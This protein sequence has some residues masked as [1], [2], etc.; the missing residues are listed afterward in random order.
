[1]GYGEVYLGDVRAAQ[2]KHLQL[3]HD[4]E[5]AEGLQDRG[6]ATERAHHGAGTEAQAQSERPKRVP[7]HQTRCRK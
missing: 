4:P 2:E 6:A 5:A 3:R 7:R 1:M